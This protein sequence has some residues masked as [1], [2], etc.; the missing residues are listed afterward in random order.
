VE[1]PWSMAFSTTLWLTALQLQ[2][3]TG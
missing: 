3:I 1:A 2:M